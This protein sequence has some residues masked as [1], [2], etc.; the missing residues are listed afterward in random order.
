MIPVK[1]HIHVR[2]VSMRREKKRRQ[3]EVK[4]KLKGSRKK[5]KI[6]EIDKQLKWR[7]HKTTKL[8]TLTRPYSNIGNRP[9]VMTWCIPFYLVL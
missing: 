7:N 1:E 5:W 9:Q 2:K 6:G 8:F 4:K 3:N